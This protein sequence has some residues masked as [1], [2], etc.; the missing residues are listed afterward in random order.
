MKKKLK[1]N[2]LIASATVAIS[3][4]FVGSN[5]NIQAKNYHQA[6]T[7]IAG[8]GNFAVYHRVSKNGPA[9]KFTSTKYFKHGQIQSKQSL[10]TKKGTFWEN[11]R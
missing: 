7:K 10:A 6:V 5:S 4:F 1:H 11:Y 9:G 2:L 8:D 3:L